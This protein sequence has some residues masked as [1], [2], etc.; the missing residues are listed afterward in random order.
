MDKGMDVYASAEGKDK[1]TLRIKWI[2]VNRP[3]VHK[4]MNDGAAMQNLRDLGF[5]KL[6]MTD[7]HSGDWGVVLDSK[8]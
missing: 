2:L 7:G 4:M 5:K 1:T 8:R 6:V 3:L